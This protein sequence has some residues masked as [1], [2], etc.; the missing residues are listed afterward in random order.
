M[1]IRILNI[2]GEI[3]LI[4]R[5]LLI[6]FG[7]LSYRRYN[8]FNKLKI[9]GTENLENLPERKVLFVSN[10]QTY[11]ADV[12]GMVH[13]FSAVKN[14][15]KNTIKNPIY[16][17]NPK[18]NLYFVSAKE[19]L[20]NSFLGRIMSYAGAV[21]VQR[22]WRESGKEVN[23]KIN[24]K[25]T[26]N[27]GKALSDGWVITFP[28][29]TTKAFSP[30]RKG[31]AHIIKQY[32]PLVIPIHIDGFRRVYDKRGLF[33]KKK[34]QKKEIFFKRPLNIDYENDS[35]DFIMN[36]IMSSIEQSE[37]FIKI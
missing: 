6:I 25:D 24:V 9:S 31:T 8:G 16:L 20:E 5:I 7:I 23:K 26:E 27:I 37:R 32:K 30:G 12:A 35:V 28:Q 15:F 17:L 33:V 13:I 34:G 2:F 4:K 14:G 22:T 19:T 3:V 10:H 29:G 36:Y 11:F 1:R 18:M 21:K